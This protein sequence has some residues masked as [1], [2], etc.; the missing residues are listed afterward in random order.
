MRVVVEWAR[1]EGNGQC[2]VEAPEVFELDA[3]DN[4]TVLDEHPSEELRHKVELAVRSCPKRAL[5]VEG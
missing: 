1:C 2:A 3:A 4:L 5:S